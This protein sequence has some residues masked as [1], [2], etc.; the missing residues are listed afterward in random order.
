MLRKISNRLSKTARV[1]FTG[2]VEVSGTR[3]IPPITMEEVQE[4]KQFFPMEKFFIFGHARSGTTLLTRLIR[5][6]A[7]VHCN[8]QGHFFTRP[9]LVSGMAAGKEFEAWLSRPSNRWNRGRDL[10]PAALRAMVD[11]I[12]ER[13]ARQLGKSIVGDKSPN[14]LLNGEAVRE[15]H[16]L[17][18]DAR[19]I[20]IIRDGRDTLISHRFQNFI[21]APQH[22]P[23]EDLR[24]RDQFSKDPEP[25]FR[26]ERSIFT[27]KAL[28]RMAAGWVENAAETD[29]IGR[30]LYGSQYLSL[31]YED[32]LSQTYGE[33]SRVWDFLGAA[34]AG[35]EHAVAAEMGSNPDAAW[36]K[37]KAGDLVANL[38]KGKRGSWRDLF[39]E[40]D[41]RIFKQIAGTT[42]VDWHYEQG[43]GW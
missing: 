8:Y 41:K 38:E 42:L 9:P 6:H 27:E 7:D 24:I 23:K 21:D 35:Y 4:A 3:A 18:P 13:E 12:M 5:L 26:G 40:R 43:M 17:Y 1:F 36:Q 25:F 11:F 32:L 14:V 15:M 22:L 30:Q 34:P 29:R 39:T 28:Q 31:R 37:Q 20:Y 19:L 16:N 2:R 33:I 10:T